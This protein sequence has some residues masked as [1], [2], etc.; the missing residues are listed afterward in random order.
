[1]LGAY[2][3]GDVV[4]TMVVFLLW[5]GFLAIGLWLLVALIRNRNLPLWAKLALGVFVVFIPWL[6][7]IALFVVWFV[8]RSSGRDDVELVEFRSWKT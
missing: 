2:S 5:V 3:S 8:T 6:G 4:W 1:M 7:V